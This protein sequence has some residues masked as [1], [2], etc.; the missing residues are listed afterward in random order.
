MLDSNEELRQVYCEKFP[1]AFDEGVALGGRDAEFIFIDGMLVLDIGG[2]HG[3]L[4]GSINFNSGQVVAA[5]KQTTLWESFYKAYEEQ[6]LSKSQIY[7]KLDSIF[8]KRDGQFTSFKNY[9]SHKFEFF[10]LERGGGASNCKIKFNNQSY[11]FCTRREGVPALDSHKLH[12]L[13]Y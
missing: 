7:D 3:K 5:G 10:Y 12:F 2:I 13:L 8:N 4:D 9:S 6:G 1:G 11:I